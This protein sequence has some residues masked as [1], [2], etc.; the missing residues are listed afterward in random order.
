MRAVLQRLAQRRGCAVPRRRALAVPSCAGLAALTAL[1]AP[2]Q[3]EPATEVE[4]AGAG[5]PVRVWYRSSEGCPDGVS[6]VERLSQLG[7]P[8]A[9]ASVGDRVDFV[10]T[11]AVRPEASAGRLERQ[12]ERGTVAIREVESPACA[13]V[14]EALALS[15]ELALD[16]ALASNAAAA[17]TS[18]ATTSPATTSLTLASAPSPPGTAPEP[19]RLPAVR[20]AQLADS[21]WALGAQGR[22]ALGLGPELTPGAAL[23]AELTQ[24]GWPH[25]ARFGV[26]GAYGQGG[27]S[28]TRVSVL[29][30]AGELDVCVWRWRAGAL[31]LEPCLGVDLGL[32]SASSG[33]PRARADR[34]LWASAR[35]L[36]RS[37]LALWPALEPELQLGLLLP[38][39]RYAFGAPEGD[40]LFRVRAVGGELS[41]G[42][43]WAP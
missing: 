7:R 27:E 11:L 35:G 19:D 26:H 23:F 28:A 8:A 15:L 17:A 25:A 4:P 24:E 2:A 38:F 9:L 43:R 34:G 10:V 30:V 22:L 31:S 39:T 16:P 33:G 5:A 6:F 37:R 20:G 14:A 13:D 41:V 1:A 18:P 21:A 36:L 29:S 3:A 32:I 12:T 42:A 40:D